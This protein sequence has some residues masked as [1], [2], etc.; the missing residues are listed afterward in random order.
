MGI[1]MRALLALAL[2]AGALAVNMNAEVSETDGMALMESLGLGGAQQSV[3]KSV[4]QA[5]KAQEAEKAEDAE[6]A[7]LMAKLGGLDK[8]K[9]AAEAEATKKDIEA[10]KATAAKLKAV[11]AQK[12]AAAKAAIDAKAK[13]VEAVALAAQKDAETAISDTKKL[14]G[15]SAA[16][17]AKA[18]AASA[19]YQGALASGMSKGVAELALKA[20][21]AMAEAQ[22]V[23]ASAGA[24]SDAAKAALANAARIKAKADK[25][26][27]M[28]KENKKQLVSEGIQ[29][30][31]G[32][33]FGK[34]QRLCNQDYPMFRKEYRKI[35]MSPA[36]K[37]Y[38]W[39]IKQACKKAHNDDLEK[40]SAADKADERKAK[41]DAKRNPHAPN[42]DNSKPFPDSQTHWSLPASK[43]VKK[44]CTTK[45]G[46]VPCSMLKK[47]QK[48]GL[49]GSAN[50]KDNF[51]QDSEGLDIVDPL[52]DFE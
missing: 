45:F 9:K 26:I 13:K 48:A 35:R 33:I 42:P 14:R 1:M 16:L 2:C 5:R 8:E 34:M 21:K 44:W 11:A 18:K 31:A 29:W 10:K 7:R 41:A 37:H 50:D 27:A 36:F 22:A 46:A 4:W 23:A 30:A 19:E 39:D 47:A 28:E 40:D 6:I 52:D 43:K 25:A 32:P 49:L 15:K 51:L 20:K 24:S 12:L 17:M 38:R 3:D